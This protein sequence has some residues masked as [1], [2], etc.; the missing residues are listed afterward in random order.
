MARSDHPHRTPL[1]SVCLMCGAVLLCWLA[2]TI[3]MLWL[4]IFVYA[5][6]AIAAVTGFAMMFRGSSF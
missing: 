2:S 3:G 1:Y 4:S 6:G 5:L